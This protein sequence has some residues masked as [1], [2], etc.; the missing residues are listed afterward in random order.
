M[1]YSTVAI[2]VSFSQWD[3]DRSNPQLVL[4]FSNPSSQTRTLVLPC[5]LNENATTFGSPERPILVLIARELVTSGEEGFTLTDLSNRTR[6]AGKSLVLKPGESAEVPFPLA[7]FY[8]W[9]HAGPTESMG[10]LDCLRPGEHGVA[11]RAIMAYSDVEPVR[12]E[13]LESPPTEL[14][15]DFPEWLFA[16][17]VGLNT[18]A[19]TDVT[20][21]LAPAAPREAAKKSAEKNP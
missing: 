19:G 21:T 10:F 2:A 15:C 12:A 16:S 14:K 3:E 4:K 18:E 5:P 9:G 20:K 17:G 1:D 13:R 11:I 7:S 6:D 8:S